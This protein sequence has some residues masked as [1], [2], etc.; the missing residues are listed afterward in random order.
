MDKTIKI[1]IVY[2]PFTVNYIFVL[3]GT[4]RKVYL[5][6]SCRDFED[7]SFS[8]YKYYRQT[9]KV[10]NT[11]VRRD[12]NQRRATFEGMLQETSRMAGKRRIGAPKATKSTRKSN[13]REERAFEKAEERRKRTGRLSTGDPA[14]VIAMCKSEPHDYMDYMR[15]RTKTLMD[16]LFGDNK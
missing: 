12:N 3:D 14:K 13:M 1:K 2:N 8:E 11:A 7:M 6:P 5:Q 9:E 16:E 10:N 15:E 4:Y